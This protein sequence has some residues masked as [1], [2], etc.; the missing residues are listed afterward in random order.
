MMDQLARTKKAIADND[1]W[2]M[3]DIN[4]IMK[5]LIV[6]IYAVEKE[7]R[8]FT[9]LSSEEKKEVAVETINWMINIPYIP[10]GMEKMLW[11]MVVDISISLANNWLGRDWAD[12][13]PT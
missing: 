12:R 3:G 11:G 6:V 5:A 1:G 2:D 9:N 8:E 10:E 4:D 13:L 7:S